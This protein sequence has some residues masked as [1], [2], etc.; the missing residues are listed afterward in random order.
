MFVRV[1]DKD[2]GHQLDVAETDPRIGG[3]FELLNRKT[4]PPSP[5]IRPT[6]HRLRPTGAASTTKTESAEAGLTD[7]EA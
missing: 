7:K 2:T 4:Y 1:R 5:V 3:P 6:K